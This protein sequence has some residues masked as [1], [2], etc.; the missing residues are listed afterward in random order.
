MQWMEDVAFTMSCGIAIT[1]IAIDVKKTWTIGHH[2]FWKQ[3]EQVIFPDSAKYS[4]SQCPIFYIKENT[5][6]KSDANMNPSRWQWLTVSWWRTAL[7]LDLWS[8]H[9]TNSICYIILTLN[10]SRNAN[11]LIYVSNVTILI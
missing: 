1:I 11:T 8:D 6:K 2:S 4:D 5:E 3:V 9:K 7:K 10:Y